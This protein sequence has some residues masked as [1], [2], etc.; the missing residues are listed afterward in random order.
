MHEYALAKSY[1]SY[2]DEARN[3]INNQD[4]N[5]LLVTLLDSVIKNIANS[6]VQSVRQDVHTPF[7]EVFNAVKET[8]KKDKE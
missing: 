4:N 3:I 2:R 1:I 7:S 5:A 6:P 8:I